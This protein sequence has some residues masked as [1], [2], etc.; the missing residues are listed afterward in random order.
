MSPLDLFAGSHTVHLFGH[1]LSLGPSGIAAIIGWALFATGALN[2]ARQHVAGGRFGSLPPL[3][4]AGVTLAA[5]SAGLG[6]LLMDSY[7]TF[8]RTF[9]LPYALLAVA[10]A[11][12]GRAMQAGGR[13]I[14]EE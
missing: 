13:P 4:G 7:P 9:C 14:G 6:L 8:A 2:A 3:A 5:I 10:V 1:S 11:I 12:V